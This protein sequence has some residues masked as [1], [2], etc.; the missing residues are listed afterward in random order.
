MSTAKQEL[1]AI[2]IDYADKIPDQVYIDILNRV[3]EIPDHI[4]PRQAG[5]IQQELDDTNVELRVQTE[6]ND[7]LVDEIYRVEAQRIKLNDMYKSQK[8]LIEKLKLEKR[9][10]ANETWTLDKLYDRIKPNNKERLIEEKD[11]NYFN[12]LSS[13]ETSIDTIEEEETLEDIY[14]LFSGEKSSEF[15][16]GIYDLFQSLSDTTKYGYYKYV[17]RYPWP[18]VG[19]ELT[20]YLLNGLNDLYKLRLEELQDDR[21]GINYLTHMETSY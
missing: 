3:A 9:Y 13:G 10:L 17:S 15:D 14:N 6:R 18:T 21:T 5:E 20:T 8:K 11:Y 16:Y 2:L 4:D 12:I 7:I 19:H 1:S